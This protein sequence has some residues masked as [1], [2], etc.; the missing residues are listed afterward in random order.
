MYASAST[1]FSNSVCSL[2]FCR[3][4][5]DTNK[6]ITRSGQPKAQRFAMVTVVEPMTSIFSAVASPYSSRLYNA[7]KFISLPIHASL[8]RL[9]L[10][11]Q[12]VRSDALVVA[13]LHILA[14]L[15]S[16]RKSREVVNDHA[17]SGYAL[18][19]QP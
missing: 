2:N 4:E 1:S 6:D 9:V 10:G 18:H 12:S 8:L 16:A 17:V 13:Y 5:P 14:D 7:S 15:E 11:L 3:Y 19:K